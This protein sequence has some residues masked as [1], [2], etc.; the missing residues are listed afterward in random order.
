[1]AD[2]QFQNAIVQ[3][4]DLIASEQQIT[5]LQRSNANQAGSEWIIE[6]LATEID[7]FWYDPH[8]GIFFES[9]YGRFEDVF[10]EDAKT[11]GRQR[12]AT[13]HS[14]D[15]KF[16]EAVT[17]FKKIFG[18]L[19]LDPTINTAKRSSYESSLTTNSKRPVH[20]WS[21]FTTQCRHPD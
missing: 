18:R 12:E 21:A 4:T 13:T 8:S 6:A 15:F 2:Q 20:L 10:K 14:R 19:L 16:E 1:M 3:F 11:D 17:K 7:E 5:D 9:W